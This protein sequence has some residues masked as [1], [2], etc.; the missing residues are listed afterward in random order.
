MVAAQMA[1]AAA[2]TPPAEARFAVD[3]E[4]FAQLVRLLSTHNRAG[5]PCAPALS[6]Y[7][8]YTRLAAVPARRRT[9]EH[10]D[11]PLSDFDSACPLLCL[12][13]AALAPAWERAL[14]PHAARFELLPCRE[15]NIMFGCHT[16]SLMH[17]DGSDIS[18]RCTE[19]SVTNAAHGAWPY[20]DAGSAA[21]TDTRDYITDAFIEAQERGG[22][23]TRHD[24]VPFVAL[25]LLPMT[26]HQVEAIGLWNAIAF[27][28]SSSPPPWS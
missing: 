26:P 10:H 16:K 8:L 11:Y 19:F 25:L 2:Q 22:F 6:V 27:A 23:V 13:N 5:Q 15:L 1:C 17:I 9:G 7:A 24:L 12:L 20:A 3:A 4:C 14:A 18:S 21:A 28:S